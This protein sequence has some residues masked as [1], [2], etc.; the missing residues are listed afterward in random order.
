MSADFLRL[1]YCPECNF[2]DVLGKQL[3]ESM[4]GHRA[5]LCGSV[6]EAELVAVGSVFYFGHSLYCLK[7]DVLS[8]YGLRQIAKCLLLGKPCIKVWG[9]GFMFP[10]AGELLL[11]MC[12]LDVHC[13]RGLLTR[14]ALVERGFLAPD[15][16]VAV[17]DPGLLFPR[18][19]KG[20][21]RCEC[22]IGVV[23]HYK[24]AEE[25]RALVT[26][27]RKSGANVRF[28]DVT[29]SDALGVVREIGSCSTILSSSLHGLIVADAFGIPNRHVCFSDLGISSD[30]FSAEAALFKFK[31][32]F[33]AVRRPYHP[34]PDAKRLIEDPSLCWNLAGKNDVVSGD[35][36][37]ELSD[38]L[39]RSFP[40]ALADDWRRQLK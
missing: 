18:L 21:V 20:P 10:R 7:S 2:G 25:G 4:S 38:G 12:S 33:S 37:D 31:D 6:R 3:V 1:H 22:D 9:S 35:L 8:F 34:I 29:Q 17:G 15:Q 11:R 23:A 39:I 30:G 27:L 32:Y 24:D 13:V 14:D 28:I 5:V 36:L 16:K 26:A 19:L 40:L